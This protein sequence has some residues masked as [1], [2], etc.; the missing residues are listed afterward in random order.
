[1]ASAIEFFTASMSSVRTYAEHCKFHLAEA[2]VA[3]SG[4]LMGTTTLDVVSLA[5]KGVAHASLRRNWLCG[6]SCG[7]NT[8]VVEGEKQTAVFRP[9]K[10]YAVKL[11]ISRRP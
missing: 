11:S 10:D 4:I 7:L 8:E 3:F 6:C 9:V 1:M 5:K 2:G